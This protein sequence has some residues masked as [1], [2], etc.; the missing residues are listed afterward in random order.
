[1]T[2][3][4][5]DAIGRMNEANIGAI[6]CPLAK[7]THRGQPDAYVFP[8]DIRDSEEVAIAVMAKFAAMDASGKGSLYA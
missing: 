7:V 2:Q 3:I 5:K 6:F 1:M 4:Q 8:Q